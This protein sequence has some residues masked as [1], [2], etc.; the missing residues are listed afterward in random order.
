MYEFDVS[1]LPLSKLL[2]S[3]H[4]NY[5]LLPRQLLDGFFG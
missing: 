4:I 5:Q 2:R 1:L 3:F